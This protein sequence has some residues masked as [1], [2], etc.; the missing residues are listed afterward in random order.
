MEKK[1]VSKKLAEWVSNVEF[2]KIPQNTVERAKVHFL[3]WVFCMIAGTSTET[4]KKSLKTAE[5]IFNG[6]LKFFNSKLSPAGVAFASGVL[7]HILEMD[8]LHRES[9]LH[10]ASPIISSVFASSLMNECEGREI[11]EG[12]VAGYDAGISVGECLGREHYRMF[13]TTATAGLFGGIA[14]SGKIVGLSEEELVWAF[15]NGGSFA[16]GLWEFLES[17]G[18]TKPIHPGKS[19]FE[20]ILLVHM[21]KNGLKGPS[22]I[23][24]GRRGICKVLSRNC[25]PGAFELENHRID[26]VSLKLYP[27]CRHTHPA[28]DAVLNAGIDWK[29]VKKIIVYT[30]REAIEVAGIRNPENTFE[31]KFSIPYCVSTG[32]LFGTVE[33]KHFSEDYINNR[34]VK[35]TMEKVIVLEDET[36]SEEFPERWGARLIF[37]DGERR[38]VQVEFPRGDP[39]NRATMEEL[40]SKYESMMSYSGYSVDVKEIVDFIMSVEKRTSLELME[41]LRSLWTSFTI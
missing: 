9:I 19:A 37:E 20:S 35:R 41:I 21:A 18:D 5:N 17:G 28:I 40:I 23:F 4:G 8:D 30:Y 26:E 2:R 31:A 13:H 27:S 39:E 29:T 38:E 32:L 7:S 36:L 16:S 10:P 11:L 6:N 14:G 15:G 3:D 24:E 12:V 34:A 22:R 33:L 25:N 1:S